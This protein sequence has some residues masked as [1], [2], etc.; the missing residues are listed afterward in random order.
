MGFY[1][2]I[3]ASSEELDENWAYAY[4]RWAHGLL[5]LKREDWNAARDSLK[6][7]SELWKE[8]NYPYHYA[9]TV[10]ELGKLLA[11]DGEEARKCLEE[12]KSVFTRLGA[13]LDLKKLKNDPQL[14]ES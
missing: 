3:K 1:A 10:S 7:S 6:K 2:R 5:A 9:Q 8:L 11:Q 4:E 13:N 14:L 12:A